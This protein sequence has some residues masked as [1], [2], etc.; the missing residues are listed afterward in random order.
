MRERSVAKK[1]YRKAIL[2][3]LFMVIIAVA[4]QVKSNQIVDTTK[5]FRGQ[6]QEFMVTIGEETFDVVVSPSEI[7]EGE[8]SKENGLVDRESTKQ[9]FTRYLNRLDRENEGEA[10]ILPKEYEGKAVM[11]ETPTDYGA[12]LLLFLGVFMAALVLGEPYYERNRARL[13]RRELLLAEYPQMVAL[14]TILMGSGMSLRQSLR[15][16]TSGEQL[17]KEGPLFQELYQVVLKVQSGE[18]LAVALE[19]FAKSCDLHVYRKL[20]SLLLQNQEKGTKD[21]STLLEIEVKESEQL[22]LAMVK[23]KA[24]KAETKVLLPI[25][26]L[27]MIVVVVLM[28][29]AFMSMQI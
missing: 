15:E 2:I 11:W 29:P 10:L 3:L 8:D 25:T 19:Q 13:K 5:V 1:R 27:L 9:A 6:H 23:E 4:Y 17:K 24:Q 12:V 7:S 16:M 20:V 21:L 26:M 22:R 18:V 28:V 14:L